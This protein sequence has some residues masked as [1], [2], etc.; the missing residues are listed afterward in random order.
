MKTNRNGQALVLSTAELDLLIEELPGGV[1]TVLASVC[2]RTGCRISEARQLK[3]ENI[4]PGGITFPKSVCKNK[5][6]S[7]TIPIFSNLYDLL[8]EWKKEQELIKGEQLSPGAWVFVGRFG[9]K[10]ITRQAHGKQLQKTIKRL[11]LLGVSSHSYRRSA[12]TSASSKGLPLKAIQTLSGHK[13]L[14]VLSKYL[15]VSEQER[16]NVAQAFA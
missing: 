16:M 5:L 13:S 11:G 3:W 12:L 1:H 15:E 2:R 9:D 10:P 8:M 7:R 14:A 4:F 6:E